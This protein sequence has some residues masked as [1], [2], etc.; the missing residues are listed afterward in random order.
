MPS[1]QKWTNREY[2]V[3]HNKYVKYQCRK[4]YGATN[5]FP[6]FKF[7]GPHNKLHS[8]HGLVNHYHMYFDTKIGHG[9]CEMRHITLVY[10][11]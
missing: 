3:Q 4:I 6:E 11:Q 2:H 10:I 5:Q 8:V 9:I 1:K 7:L